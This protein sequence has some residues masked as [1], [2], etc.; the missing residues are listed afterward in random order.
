M[1]ITTRATLP[2][3]LE[4]ELTMP[5]LFSILATVGAVPS[6]QVL[7]MINLLTED[8][9]YR[10]TPPGV[11]A[12]QSQIARQ[13]RFMRG[14]YAIAMLCITE[15]ADLKPTDLTFA[16]LEAVYFGFFRGYRR[17]APPA[18]ATGA[19]LD[20]DGDTGASAAS[21]DVGN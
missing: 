2:S 18:H 20:A 4:V 14:V 13:V 7:D 21:G 8:R 9:V 15:P 10:P 6:Q 17:E 1:A 16:D 3:G 19:D 5:D 11:T 12:D